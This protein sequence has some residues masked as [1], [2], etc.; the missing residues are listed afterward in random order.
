MREFH[1]PISSAWRIST[2][3]RRTEPSSRSQARARLPEC[4]SHEE[5]CG[6]CFNLFVAFRLLSL[7]AD[8]RG[9]AT[10][11][12]TASRLPNSLS[13]LRRLRSAGKARRGKS[14]RISNCRWWH[15]RAVLQAV[16]RRDVS[17]GHP[18]SEPGG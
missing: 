15:A 1:P 2:S 8:T 12:V 13:H 5:R 7:G 16:C 17:D 10:Q 14:H 3:T 4:G 9:D 6:T 11:Q 18:C